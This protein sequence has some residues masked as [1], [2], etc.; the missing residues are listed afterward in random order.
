MRSEAR[1]Q[2]SVAPSEGPG[3]ESHRVYRIQLGLSGS[4]GGSERV[5]GSG[6][7][8]RLLQ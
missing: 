8:G 5:D 3:A 6:A 7:L 4:L 2:S 1:G